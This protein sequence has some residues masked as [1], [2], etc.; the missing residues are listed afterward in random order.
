MHESTFIAKNSPGILDGA[1]SDALASLR[2]PQLDRPYFYELQQVHASWQDVIEKRIIYDD[3]FDTT[4]IAP[5]IKYLSAII[6]A[7]QGRPVIQECRTSSRISAIKHKLGGIHIYL[8]RNPWDQWWSFKLND[9]F[10]AA[11]QL[12][13]GAQNAPPVI[14][15][16]REHIDYIEF[17]HADISTEFDHY[18]QHPLSSESSYLLFY[19]LWSLA[20][21]EGANHA[22]ILINID[23]LSTNKDYLNQTIDQLKSLGVTEVDFADCKIPQ[24][25]FHTQDIDFFTAIEDRVTGWLLVSGYSQKD[26]GLIRQLQSHYSPDRKTNAIVLE[27]DL[28]RARDAVLRLGTSESLHLKQLHIHIHD[29]E[30]QAETNKAELD[31]QFQANVKELE[32]QH[33][34][35]KRLSNEHTSFLN[36][37][38]HRVLSD[39]AECER[40]WSDR[41][42]TLQQ[43][44][45]NIL[46][47]QVKREQE[48]VV[49]TITSQQQANAEKAELSQ[50]HQ[51]QLQKMLD[52]QAEHEWQ[53]TERIQMLNQEL[54]RLKAD[55]DTREQNHAET[56]KLLQKELFSLLY[57]QTQR[58]QELAAQI[59]TSQQQANA[60]KAELGQQY[61]AQMQK[62]LDQR[63][64]HVAREQE[65]FARLIAQQESHLTALA[66]VRTLE[67]QLTDLR[68]CERQLQTSLTRQTEYGETL[69]QHIA[70]MQRTWPC[71]LNAL[72][73]PA[74]RTNM[75]H[76]TVD[77]VQIF[78]VALTKDSNIINKNQQIGH[79]LKEPNVMNNNVNDLLDLHGAAF[80]TETYKILLGRNP[81]PDGMRYYLMKL[82]QGYGKP[83][84]LSQIAQSKEAKKLVEVGELPELDDDAFINAIYHA[85]LRRDVDPD[86][87]KHYLKLLNAG[88]PRRKIIADIK[89]SSEAKKL[90]PRLSGLDE[91]FAEEYWANHWL[92]GWFMRHRRLE[93]Q[94]NRLGYETSGSNQRVFTLMQ[95][96]RMQTVAF[97]ERSS[98]QLEQIQDQI[99]IGGGMHQTK[100]IQIS[101]PLDPQLSTSSVPK[102]LHRVY[103]ENY[104]PFYDPFL[105]YLETWKR[106]LP[107]YEIIK[108]GPG[109]VDTSVN[110]WMRRSA[111]ANDPV[112]LSEFVRWDA[113]KKYGG[114]YLDSDCEVL[115]GQKFDALVE[116]LMVSTEYDAF[117]GVEEFYNGHPT[118]QTVAAKKGAAL[119]NFMYDM[120]TDTLSGPLWHW[121]SERGLI[122]P[123]LMSLYFREHGLAETKGFPIQLKEPIVVGR[124]KIYPQEYFSPKFTTTGTQL[125]ISENTCIYHLF[126]NLNVKEVDP[127]A[128]QHRR[129]PMLFNEYCNYL[130]KL[131][132]GKT[133]IEV[134]GDAAVESNHLVKKDA[135]LRKL[136]RIYFGFDGKPDPYRRYLD[137]WVKQMPGYEIIHW[138]TSNLP[139]NNCQF[140]RMMFEF[141]DHA[142]LSDYFRWWILREHGGVYLDAD[143]EITNG[144]L[145]DNLITELENN[146]HIHSFIGIDSKMDGWYTAHSMASK[147]NSQL[148]QFMCETYEG[149]GNVSLWRRKIFYFM[150]PQLTSLYFATNGHNVDGMGS[151]P[152]LENPTVYAG[153]KIYPQEWL[154]PMR[155]QMKDGIG[156]FEIDSY[157][158]N[159]CI[160]HHFSCSW[161]KDDSP[162]K[163]KLNDERKYL[164]LDELTD[165]QYDFNKF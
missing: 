27:R 142:F 148:A 123:Q 10:D 73:R 51:A 28:R 23:S 9:Y 56:I 48:M 67:Q 14:V 94:I 57:S 64:D 144:K 52:Q 45:A 19:T 118:A 65:M 157:T 26:V 164:L 127:E 2:H 120:Y 150:A 93:R 66:E 162:F 46:R 145:L 114:I 134:L 92:T 71:R 1:T 44:I 99:K 33:S 86:G 143:V 29:L 160:C 131:K 20:L 163:S 11:C 116:E 106:E 25:Y 159:T 31:Q 54:L 24:A 128:E 138:N 49:Q 151:T 76:K 30:Q 155:P 137:T 102:I 103:F 141:K 69:A 41:A 43:E 50:Q 147:K 15:R 117:V 121:R 140:S 113:L 74:H 78:N 72:F 158:K 119:V 79:K 96:N 13:L 35:D 61:Q 75:R 4:S 108:W 47:T 59:I 85:V 68:I 115:N 139:V 42:V 12:I 53:A 126:A 7:A 22:D 152:N 95:Q 101:K 5:L 165:F 124:V 18:K 32:R 149:L 82:A 122:G 88:K 107:N 125:A 84:V 16:L 130:S 80:V 17:H 156:G 6:L 55:Y 146:E 34:E 91:L 8:W 40:I 60:E 38:L 129:N 39:R 87:K 3:Y 62:M 136:H 112:F 105:H 70:D 104:S 98:A 111:D 133:D 154:S 58:E 153:V 21:I 37:E 161:H 110:E 109:N 90:G 83:A 97:A 77:K 81:D 36:Q 100:K 135:G 89:R 132:V 63:A